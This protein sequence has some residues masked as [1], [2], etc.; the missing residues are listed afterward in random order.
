MIGCWATSV[1][2]C[3]TSLFSVFHMLSLFELTLSGVRQVRHVESVLVPLV[4][5]DWMFSYESEHENKNWNDETKQIKREHK[6][7]GC[8]LL[9]F[10]KYMQTILLGNSM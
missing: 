1:S 4:H 8:H 9:A 2:I 3:L 10:R 6:V 7:A 5:S